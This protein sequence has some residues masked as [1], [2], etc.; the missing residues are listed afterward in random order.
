[1]TKCEENKGVA[2]STPC[3]SAGRLGSPDHSNSSD[4]ETFPTGSV[5]QAWT[6][7][8]HSYTGPESTSGILFLPGWKT[9]PKETPCL[10]ATCLVLDASTHDF[11]R[12]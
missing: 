4:W 6:S 2:K 1:M 8:L 7:Q 5:N 10:G 11:T 12:N 9:L 3:P